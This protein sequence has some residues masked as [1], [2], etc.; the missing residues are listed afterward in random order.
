[1]SELGGVKRSYVFSQIA[2]VVFGWLEPDP[3]EPE[4]GVRVEIRLVRDAGHRG[5]P[6]AAQEVALD[7]PL[8]RADLFDLISREPGN[9]LRAHYHSSFEGVEPGER[10]W[11]GRLSADPFGWL[12]EQLGDLEA[13]VARAGFASVVDADALATDA[14]ALRVISAEVVGAA[15]GVSAQI[16]ALATG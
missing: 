7:Q 5:S 11:D 8:F 9:F 6:S 3:D 4:R 14:A 10:Q 1:M 13:I 2:V 12:A 15:Q 16:R